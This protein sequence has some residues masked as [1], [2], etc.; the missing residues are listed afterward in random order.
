MWLL[1]QCLT[2]S[3]VH[4]CSKSNVMKFPYLKGKEV[5][6]VCKALGDS[7]MSGAV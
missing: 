4:L 2:L 6:N 5:I 3:F 1:P 7:E